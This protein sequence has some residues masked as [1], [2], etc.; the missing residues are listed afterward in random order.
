MNGGSRV[1]RLV[2]LAWPAGNPLARGADRLEAAL[3]VLAV[4]AGLMLLPV[5]L[6]AGSLT[7]GSL[8]DTARQEASSRHRTVATLTED[9]PESSVGG[10]GNAFVGQSQ[11]PAEWTLPDGATRSGPVRA[12]DGLPAGAKVEIWLDRDGRV[13]DQP[14]SPTDAAAGAAIVALTGW[15]TA[16]FLLGL[17]QLAVH[18]L[19][20][21][22]RY[23][24]WDEEWA[25]VEPDWNY[26]R[27]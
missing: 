19:L 10:Y 9:A 11:V 8:A 6:V 21:R 23:R 26:F 1:A 4:L 24:G 2:R 3:L 16:V 17:G 7:Y 27:H 25:E 12:R 15:L 18:R 13:T 22:R 14:V 5:M 20:D